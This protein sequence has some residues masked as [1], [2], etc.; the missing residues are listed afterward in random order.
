MTWYRS[1][2][3]GSLQGR[4]VRGVQHGSE[5]AGR[6]ARWALLA[7]TVLLAGCSYIFDDGAPAFPLLGDPILPSRY[8]QMNVQMGPARDVYLLQGAETT[9]DHDSYWAALPEAQPEVWPPPE[10]WP[11]HVRLIRLVDGVREDWTADQIQYGGSMLYLFQRPP[12]GDPGP[13]KLQVRRPGAVDPVGRFDLPPDGGVMLLAPNDTSFAYVTTGKGKPKILLRRTDGSRPRD[14]SLPEGFESSQ[15]TDQTRLFMEPKGDFFVTQD[16]TGLIRTFSTISATDRMLGQF[17]YDAVL[18]SRAR[19][20]FC[21]GKRGLVRLD[22]VPGTAQTLD[23]MPCQAA[24]LRLSGGAV[25]YGRDGALYTV[26]AAGGTPA[27][28][29]LP[30]G[31]EPV[32][33]LLGVGPGPERALAYSLNPALLYGPGIG[34]GWL[35]DWQFMQR[36]RRP[37]WSVDSE[38]S[39]IRWLENAARSDSTGEL[40]SALIADRDRVRPLMLARNVRQWLEVSPGRVLAISNAAGRGVYNRLIDIDENRGEAHWLVDSARDFIRIP[41]TDD[42]IVRIVHG[43]A[44]YDVYR[45]PI[46]RR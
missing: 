46:P 2:E 21:C 45:V 39:R 37:T 17:D 14:V 18:D 44:G 24:L 12:E 29:A 31:G 1:F 42:L 9:A 25:Y 26:D 3:M 7:G 33:Q 6:G 38:A 20:L 19:A 36:G 32:G 27:Y 43:Q 34:D 15:P 13:T 4:A 16:A 10:H 23:P 5:G 22:L 40:M 30:T 35:G 41:G 8:P 28:V 11:E